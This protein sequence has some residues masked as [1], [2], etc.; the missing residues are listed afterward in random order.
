MVNFE[1]VSSTANAEARLLS[2]HAWRVL[3]DVRELRFFTIPSK[4][5][6]G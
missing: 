2:G 1:I 5:V 4:Y 6:T 3:C